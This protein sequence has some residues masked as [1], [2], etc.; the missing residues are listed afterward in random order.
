MCE[1][2]RMAQRQPRVLGQTQQEVKVEVLVAL[3][4]HLPHQRLNHDVHRQRGHDG[5]ALREVRLRKKRVKLR[6]QKKKEVKILF[7]WNFLSVLCF[8]RGRT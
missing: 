1:Q 5:Q 3:Q 8:L 4:L 2:Q 7:K 6:K